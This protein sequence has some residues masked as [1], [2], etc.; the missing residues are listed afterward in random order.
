[1]QTLIET[2]L[3]NSDYVELTA[4]ENVLIDLKY[5]SNDNFTRTN[6]YGD[7]NRAFLHR[8]AFEKFQLAI[9]HLRA[10]G[11]KRKFIIYDAL[12]PRSVQYRL[13]EYVKGTPQEMYIAN[14]D[15]GSIHNYGFAVDLSLVDENNKPIDMGT[16][17]DD[18]SDLAQ[19]QLENQ[20]LQN[21]QL[22]NLQ[23][24]E[25]H[26]LRDIMKQAGFT[27]LPHEWW[28]F[29]ALDRTTV[30]SHFSIVE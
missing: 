29:E 25:R 14:P 5:A 20:F 9:K 19:P 11:R 4:C 2:L 6:I 26:Y 8:I 10:D 1:M 30:K 22:T 27:Q 7:F 3:I 15:L 18:F 16:P 17:F 21:G 28:H 12:R 23:L 13:F 24:A